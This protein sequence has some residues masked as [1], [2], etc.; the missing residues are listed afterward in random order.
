MPVFVS[1]L[2]CP[3][4]CIYCNQ[5]KI[6]GVSKKYDV[7]ELEKYINENLSYYNDKT[8]PVQLAFY[9]GSFTGID[10]GTQISYLKCVRKFIEKGLI[11]SIRISTRPDYITK[12]I[13]EY[14]LHY[15]VKTIELGVQSLNDNVLLASK[16]GHT[17]L[18]VK[19]ASELIKNYGFELGHQIMPGL[20]GDNINTIKETLDK[21]ISMKPD[22]VRIYPLLVL[23]DTL[24]EKMYLNNEYIP[25]TLEEAVE[26]STFSI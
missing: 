7:S 1:D 26:I 17:Y 3:F 12:N 11:E 8:K 24:L 4:Q 15:D 10:Y 18:D 22:L 19:N 6:T 16:R 5:K 9:G 2:G 25:L 20:I 23:K 14:L 13:L 21:S